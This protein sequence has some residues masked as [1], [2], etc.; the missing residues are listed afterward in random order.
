[1][2]ASSQR[3][4]HAND[5]ELPVPL[6]LARHGDASERRLRPP[7]P[8][9]R[10]C[11]APHPFL[12]CTGGVNTRINFVFCPILSQALLKSVLQERWPP[13]A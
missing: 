10:S 9:A 13:R 3:G 2:G 12:G 5:N 8:Q 6:L 7:F 11:P 1:M 4:P